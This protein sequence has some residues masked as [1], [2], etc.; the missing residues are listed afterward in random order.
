M[1]RDQW[2]AMQRASRGG[3]RA[4]GLYGGQTM[5]LPA[6]QAKRARYERQADLNDTLSARERAKRADALQRAD[7]ILLSARRYKPSSG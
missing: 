5:S 4:C 3:A 7:M 6:R 2:N 1:T